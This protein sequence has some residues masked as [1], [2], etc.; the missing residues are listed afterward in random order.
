[1][2]IEFGSL[3]YKMK[4]ISS[5]LGIRQSCIPDYTV[6]GLDFR[7]WASDLYGT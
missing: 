6:N 4:I 7:I 3:L 5:K 2:Y 1:M